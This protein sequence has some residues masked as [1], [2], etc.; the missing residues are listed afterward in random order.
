MIITLLIERVKELDA[1]ISKSSDNHQI[2]NLISLRTI[3]ENIFLFITKKR[4][5]FMN[6]QREDQEEAIH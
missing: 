1:L 6:K 3:N 2:R 5:N 4:N